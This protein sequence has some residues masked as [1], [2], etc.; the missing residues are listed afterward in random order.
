MLGLGRRL[1]GWS[2]LAAT[3]G[4]LHYST[5]C[6]SAQTAFAEPKVKAALLFNFAKFVDWP[7]AEQDD[8]MVI[9]VLGNDDELFEALAELVE[10]KTIGHSVVSTQRFQTLRELRMCHVLFIG[11]E[12]RAQ[13]NRALAVVSSGAVL[14][15]GDGRQF[16]R[17]G[18]M[19]GLYFDG[20]KPRFD[21]NN[22]AARK[23]GLR[24]RAQLL[25][26]ARSVIP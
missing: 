7:A 21:I 20:G 8:S 17:D 3:L 18:G 23:S 19:I 4:V 16:P 11:F 9:G 15:V 10:G 25:Q 14:T 6:A 24:I 13:L 12:D 5:P 1:T 26:L 22:A 2:V